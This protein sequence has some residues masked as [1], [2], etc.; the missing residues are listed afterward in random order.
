MSTLRYPIYFVHTSMG[1]WRGPAI[2]VVHALTQSRRY[3]IRGC[4][5][6]IKVHSLTLLSG[7]KREINNVLW[8]R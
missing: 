4:V 7:G 6:D 2:S 3:G 8:A 5:Y 1:S